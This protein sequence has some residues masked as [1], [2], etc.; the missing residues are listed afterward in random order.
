MD[1]EVEEQWWTG[2]EKGDHYG[3][4]MWNGPVNAHWQW[5]ES[6]TGV[7]D[8][9]IHI[10]QTA[11]KAIRYIYLIV[12]SEGMFRTHHSPAHQA[13]WACWKVSVRRKNSP[14]TNIQWN[15]YWLPAE[16]SQ[17]VILQYQV[18]KKKFKGPDSIFGFTGPTVSVTTP[19]LCFC[20]IKATLNST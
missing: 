14:Q 16:W 9:W 12:I 5:T 15:F 6:A 20:N 17:R 11:T 13:V 8:P 18:R 10:P 4:K 7:W 19:Q 3:W 1:K 2:G